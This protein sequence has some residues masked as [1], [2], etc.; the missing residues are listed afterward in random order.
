MIWE[1]FSAGKRS[2]VII[3]YYNLKLLPLRNG[4]MGKDRYLIL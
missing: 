3:S 1:D 4:W 2:I